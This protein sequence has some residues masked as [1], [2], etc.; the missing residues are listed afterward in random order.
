MQINDF[1][2]KKHDGCAPEN[3]ER[4]N[5]SGEISKDGTP[6]DEEAIDT[7]NELGATES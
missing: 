1:R 4:L 2:N 6:T 5:L 3:C 7:S